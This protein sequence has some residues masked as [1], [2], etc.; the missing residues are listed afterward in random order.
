MAKN[1]NMHKAKKNKNDEFYT[2]LTD[3]EKEVHQYKDHFKDKVIYLNCD[4]P[5]WSNFFRF[6]ASNFEYFEL[7]KLI[8]TH[9]RDD[10]PTYKLVLEHALTPKTDGT[11]E[12]DIEEFK[13]PLKQNGDFRSPECIELLKESDIVVTNPPFSLF[14]EYVTQLIEHNKKFL[15]IGNK[16]AVNYLLPYFRENLMWLG[17][18]SPE[19]FMTPD[20]DGQN[21]KTDKLKGLTRWFTNLQNTR[22][23]DRITMYKEYNEEEYPKFNNYDAINVDKVT[24]IPVDYNGYM[25]VPVTFLDKYNPR[26]FEIIGITYSTD[27]H[28]L[29]ESIRTDEKRRHVGI[30]NGKEKYPRVIIRRRRDTSED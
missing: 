10:A 27:K 28:P 17:M 20:L 1:K 25:G 12:E 24:D 15:I 6:F 19:Y 3:I 26:Q 11:F 4:D 8:S 18:T 21:V 14:R 9:Y 30:I 29:I 7:K 5:E 23:S 22:R 2:M 16:N 13:H